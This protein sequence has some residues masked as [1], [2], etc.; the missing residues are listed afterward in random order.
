MTSQIFVGLPVSDL[1]KSTKFYSA[2]GFTVNPKM[3]DETANCMVW[4]DTILVMLMS[5]EKFQSFTKKPITDAHATAPG[6]FSLT[7]ES[8]DRINEIVTKGIAAGGVEVDEFKDYGFMQERSIE[9][10]D[11]YTWG[12]LCMSMSKM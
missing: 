10:P 11:G 9:D 3:S 2:L 12:I 4:S 8:V 6:S 7:V 1:A 5:H